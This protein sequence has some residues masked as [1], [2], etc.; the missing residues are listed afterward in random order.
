[1][2]SNNESNDRASTLFRGNSDI[3]LLNSIFATPNNE[4]IR[5]NASGTTPVT[6]LARAVVLTCN[7]TKYVGTGAYDAA[8]VASLFG[9]GANG[10][11]DAFVST[12]VSL[13]INGENENK[14]TPID[15]SAAPGSAFF[16]KTAWIGAVQNASDNWYKGW[17]CDSAIADFGS[18]SAC[19]SLPT[20]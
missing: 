19:T 17:T 4:C 20:T 18:G 2:S 5:M 15:A 1:V 13:F 16:D 10:N 7:T 3:T 12:L 9:S 6:L 11:N 14:V 8:K